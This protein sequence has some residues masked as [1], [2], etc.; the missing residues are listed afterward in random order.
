[1]T[2]LSEQLQDIGLTQNQ[3]LVYLALTRAGE[4]KAGELIKK[5]GMHRNIVY[6]ALEE[7]REKKLIAAS[8]IR[9][10]ASYKALSPSQLLLAVEEKERAARHAIEQ[11]RALSHKS[12][13]QEIIVYEGIEEF[14]KHVLRSYSLTKPGGVLRYLGTSPHWHTVVGPSVEAEGMRLQIEKKIK[15]RGISKSRFSAIMKYRDK[16]KSLTSIRT[17][18][19]I[20]SDTNNVEILED[21]ICIQSFVPPYFVVEIVNKELAKNYQ[22]YFDFLWSKSR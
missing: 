17:N 21:R 1:M 4:A 18:P 14:R 12:A 11:L 22:N 9:G 2:P 7:L 19:L 3:A 10:V 8:R 5:T 16:T 6:T 20:S 15:A 13:E